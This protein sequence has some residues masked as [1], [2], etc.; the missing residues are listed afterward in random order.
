MLKVYPRAITMCS[1]ARFGVE[2][3]RKVDV[4]CAEHWYTYRSMTIEVARLER[5]CVSFV[6]HESVSHVINVCQMRMDG[7]G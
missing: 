3:D 5:I 7:C 1:I 4:G 6:Y 2:M